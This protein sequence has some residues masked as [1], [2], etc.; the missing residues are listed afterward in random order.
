MASLPESTSVT[1][2]LA[3][4]GQ[5]FTFTLFTRPLRLGAHGTVHYYWMDGSQFRTARRDSAAAANFHA[6]VGHWWAAV[7]LSGGSDDGDLQGRLA[8]AHC[9]PLVNRDKTLQT[10][11]R[12]AYLD[13][14]RLMALKA[15]KTN[16]LSPPDEVEQRIQELVRRRDRQGVQRE[17]DAALGRFEPPRNRLPGLVAAFEEWFGLGAQA[18][19]ASGTDGLERYLSD[20]AYW[21]NL[22]RKKAG[23][24]ELR[25]FLNLFAYE[26]KVS[27]YRCYANAWVDLIPWLETHRGLDP[28]SARFLKFWHHQNG[29]V[30]IWPPPLVAGTDGPTDP[31]A[32]TT[33]RDVFHGQVLSLHPLSG[34]FMKDKFDRELAGRFFRSDRVPSILTSPGAGDDPDYWN[35]VA[36][37]LAAAHR[38]RLDAD[39]LAGCRGLRSRGGD[40]VEPLTSPP[41]VTDGAGRLEEYAGAQ[42]LSCPACGGA[43]R[44]LRFSAAEPGT[45]RFLVDFVCAVCHRTVPTTIGR[46]EFTAWIQRDPD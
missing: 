32:A 45:N 42:G 25:T 22:Y 23:Q 2:T 16:A 19:R 11:Y 20:R 17:L 3:L 10:V 29:P 34:V 13:Q 30:P 35:L 41:E 40:A 5:Q 44:C 9:Y 31:T 37:L 15:R 43:L 26:A 36:A 33:L 21:L 14:T 12:D 46:A 1:A 18:V 38:Y 27:F 7:G 39:M 24:P 28:L 4:G 6:C 8:L